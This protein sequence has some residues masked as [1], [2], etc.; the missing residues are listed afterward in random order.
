MRF[1]KSKSHGFML[2]SGADKVAGAAGNACKQL[3]SC[4]SRSHPKVHFFI[5]MF[6]FVLAIDAHE[7]YFTCHV[8]FFYC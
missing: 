6:L 7:D 8:M 2:T 4:A 5:L 1:S 3:L